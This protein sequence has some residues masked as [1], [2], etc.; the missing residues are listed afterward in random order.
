MKCNTNINF[1]ISFLSFLQANF[2]C[3]TKCCIII[4]SLNQQVC[5]GCCVLTNFHNYNYLASWPKVIIITL[6]SSVI[7]IKSHSLNQILLR[8][9][10][11]MMNLKMRVLNS[12]FRHHR[13]VHKIFHFNAHSGFV[14]C[15]K[16]LFWNRIIFLGFV[17]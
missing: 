1:A 6:L 5:F 16:V 15:T 4:L 11:E 17:K 7:T 12:I 2:S 14:L 9:I 8:T 3:V 10:M 13:L